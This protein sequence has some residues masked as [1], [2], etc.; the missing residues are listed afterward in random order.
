MRILV[1]GVNGQVGGELMDLG[2]L[3]CEL[4]PADRSVLD[5][6]DPQSIEE[7]CARIAPDLVVNCA[8][9]TAVDQAEDE[10]E[11]AFAVN[12]E[13]PRHLARLN[14]AKGLPLIHISTDAV[15]DGAKTDLYLPSDPVNPLSVYGASKEAG[16][17]AI[18]EVCPSHVILRTSWVFSSRGKNFVKTMLRLSESMEPLRVVAD[19]TGRPTSAYDLSQAIVA[20][21]KKI[22]S[23]NVHWG[24]YHFCNAGATTW[25]EFALGIFAE[26]EKTLDLEPV[27]K[28]ITTREYPL[29]AKRPG[30][31]VLSTDTFEAKFEYTPRPW[32]LALADVLYVLLMDKGGA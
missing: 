14:A 4:I 6:A 8:A 18:R 25:Y 28:A 26:A 2:I 21:V 24:T 9:Y 15:F 23:G 17:R 1:T 31:A 13:G 27:V 10:P 12:A 11:V 30:K 3:G 32:R 20:V 29:K 16:E 7:A 5:L 19:Q 22:R